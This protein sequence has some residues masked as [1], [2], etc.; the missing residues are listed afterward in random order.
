MFTEKL[1]TKQIKINSYFDGLDDYDNWVGIDY[2]QKTM[3]IARLG[4]RDKTPKVV[5]LATDI[6]V[7]KMYFKNLKGRT[8][9]TIEE[10]TSTHYL[11]VELYGDVTRIV[12]CDPYTNKL[13]N[14]GP[15]NDK[16]DAKKL[17]NLLRGGF[18]KEVFH[19]LDKLYNLRVLVSGYEDL[20]KRGVRAQNQ[21]SAI[22]RMEGKEYTKKV[23]SAMLAGNFAKFVSAGLDE[24]VELYFKKKKE[25]DDTF[26]RLC[27]KDKTLNHQT[28]IPGI[29]EVNA[30]KIIATV[31]DASRFKNSNKFLSY[32]G[33]VK[34]EKW[35]GGKKYGKRMPRYIRRLKEVYK[36][37]AL[38]AIGG[39]NSIKEYYEEMINNGIPEDRARNKIA[40]YIA[41]ISYGVMKEG[42]K[43]EPYRWRKNKKEEEL[44]A[45][46]KTKV[47]SKI[48]TKVV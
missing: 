42:H 17:C 23:S 5:E 20:I 21:K 29:G 2:S 32:S 13:I 19:S 14:S 16:I 34:N 40:R 22:F 26:K 27:K 45:V 33:L 44:K 28:G 37:A 39:N 4:R 12:I 18:V 11:Y 48:Q 47:K 46:K 25:Y 41:R 7:L 38:A 6:E 35:S 3:A 9:L 31:V 36:T 10:T 8:I 15:S 43:Y 30:V 1:G 24:E